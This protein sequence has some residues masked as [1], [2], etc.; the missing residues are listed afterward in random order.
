MSKFKKGC[1]PWNK[2]LKGIIHKNKFTNYKKAW[3]SG[4]IDGEGCFIA[5]QDK[6]RHF[7]VA[8]SINLRADDIQTLYYV[9]SLFSTGRLMN[10]SKKYVSKYDNANRNAVCRLS[11]DSI[12]ELYEKVIP[13]FDE[14]PLL[15]KKGQHYKIWRKIVKIL[16]K[17]KCKKNSRNKIKSE[18]EQLIQDLHEIKKY[19]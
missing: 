10:F 9:K 8:L 15:S 17:T 12:T 3:L 5:S 18:L 14:Y 7:H 19:K 6:H 4:F 16:Y 11:I 13:I 2:G 1:I